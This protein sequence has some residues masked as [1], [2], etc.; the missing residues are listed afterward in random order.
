M[1]NNDIGNIRFDV[2]LENIARIDNEP[3]RL[4]AQRETKLTGG[5]VPRRV[6]E[7][8]QDQSLDTAMQQFAAPHL[9]DPSVLMPVRFEHLIR[10]GAQQLEEMARNGGKPALQRAGQVLD[11]EMQLRNLLANY[12]SALVQG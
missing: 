10:E 11:D 4:P 9:S 8:F 6:E 1:P 2:G 3:A 12:R 7:L 5:K